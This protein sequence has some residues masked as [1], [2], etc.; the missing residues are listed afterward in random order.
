[1]LFH[2][3]T[4]IAYA[5][6]GIFD[7]VPDTVSSIAES[8]N[9]PSS[10]CGSGRNMATDLNLSSYNDPT[11]MIVIVNAL[12]FFVDNWSVKAKRRKT[13]GTGRCRYLKIVRRRFRNGFREGGRPAPRK[14]A[15]G[16]S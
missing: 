5:F 9:E 4:Y 3:L 10:G 1:M 7:S 15:A 13:T 8:K 2:N 16:S 14:V 11:A 12:V 6:R